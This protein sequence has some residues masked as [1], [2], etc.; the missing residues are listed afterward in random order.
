MT[1]GPFVSVTPPVAVQSPG[2]RSAYPHS[3]K[4]GGGPEWR[5]LLGPSSSSVFPG[6]G[7]QA[8]DVRAAGAREPDP[9]APAPAPLAER[10][11]PPAAGRQA[12]PRPA[13]PAPAGEP[14][15]AQCPR[16]LPGSGGR[17]GQ[18][19]GPGLGSGWRGWVQ[20]QARWGALGGAWSGRGR[21]GAQVPG[22]PAS[23]GQ[24]PAQTVTS[25][26]R[27]T[28]PA[29]PFLTGRS[30]G[31]DHSC[32]SVLSLGTVTPPRGSPEGLGWSP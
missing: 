25:Q 13:E 23:P 21:V 31:G 27:P 18:G 22:R 2:T 30:Q 1:T 11:R 14:G 19:S 24:A 17:T 16:R 20:G 3:P 4:L 9:G 29:G 6:S 8:A 12:A 32:G 26:G 7:P 15:A 5:N 28:H 10:A